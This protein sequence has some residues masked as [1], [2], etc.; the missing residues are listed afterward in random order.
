MTYVFTRSGNARTATVS[1]VALLHLG[2]A[3]ALINGLG[4][5]TIR[6]QVFNLPTTSYRDDPPPQPTPPPPRPDERKAKTQ[7]DVVTSTRPLVTPSTAPVFDLPAIK[8]IE[9]VELAFPLPPA[10]TPSAV[11]EPRFAPVAPAPRGQPG[12][13]VT[14]NDYPTRDIREGN[15]GTALFKLTLTAQGAVSGC[16]I[17]RSS[18]HPGLDA[19]TCDRLMA[20][21]RFA[22]ARDAQGQATTGSYTGKI[23]WV[24]PR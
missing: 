14:S 16:E 1:V 18:G 23:T 3:W 8:P 4:V 6:E 24:I 12:N 7:P 10:P 20:R 11:P 22:P 17:T 19:A 9:P 15:E 13:W 21:A 5:A 2:G